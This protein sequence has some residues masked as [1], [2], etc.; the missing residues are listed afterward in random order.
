MLKKI[1]LV[2]MF[3]LI[4]A[5]GLKAYSLYKIVHPDEIS[6]WRE[7]DESSS[8]NID[9]SSLQTLLD[10]YLV[11]SYSTSATEKDKPPGN[12]VSTRVFNYKKVSDE[13]KRKLKAY[14]DYLQSLEPR[15]YTKNVQFA[16]WVN[17]YN[18]LT[19]HT[20]LSHYPIKSIKEIGDGFS[21]PWN[22]D[23]LTIAGQSL[24]LNNIE[25]GILRA[26][27]QDKRIHYVVN[28]ASISCPDLLP[29]TLQASSLEQQL[30]N[31]ARQYINHPRALSFDD[32]SIILSS[33]YQWFSDD[34]GQTEQDL[35]KHLMDYAKPALKEK[36]RDFSGRYNFH[37]NWELNEPH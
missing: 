12:T 9:H 22:I 7:S 16:Y 23:Y 5:A 30:D 2:V 17:L 36:L 15:Q 33:I 8:Q 14:L 4:S 3:I 10:Q 1:L 11:E 28:C 18:A 29:Q 25:H 19:I 27:W 13:D 24:S 6:F 37:Y 21:G 35:L 20:V 34:F 32:N 31:A 26:I